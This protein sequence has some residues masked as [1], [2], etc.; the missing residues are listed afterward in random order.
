[1]CPRTVNF[2]KSD[3]EGK[4][5]IFIRVMHEDGSESCLK[6]IESEIRAA[7]DFSV[8]GET[9]I[10]D[11]QIYPDIGPLLQHLVGRKIEGFE[12]NIK[13]SDSQ[14]RFIRIRLDNEQ[15]ITFAVGPDGFSYSDELPEITA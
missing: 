1:M 14:P 8:N 13:P 6:L 12:Q 2:Y 10:T 4:K 11:A 5:A 7:L 15:Q 9:S 3:I